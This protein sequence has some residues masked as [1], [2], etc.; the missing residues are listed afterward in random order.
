MADAILEPKADVAGLI[1]ACAQKEITFSV[2]RQRVSEM[3][4]DTTSLYWMVRY[5]EG[6]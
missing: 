3:G 5:A 1:N 4:Y 2:L 6:T